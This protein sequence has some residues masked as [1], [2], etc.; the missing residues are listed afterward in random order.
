MNNT[1][2]TGHRLGLYAAKVAIVLL[3]VAVIAPTPAQ[4]VTKEV[5]RTW[6]EQTVATYAELIEEATAADE[7]QARLLAI[8]TIALGSQSN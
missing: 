8:R 5:A 3:A 7:Y 2:S 1:I 6:V 4:M